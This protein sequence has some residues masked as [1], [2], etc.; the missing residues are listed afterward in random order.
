[1][2]TWL[3]L[4]LCTFILHTTAEEFSLDAQVITAPISVSTLKVM[5][6][7][8]EEFAGKY[9]NI[10]DLLQQQAGI[11]VRSSGIGNPVS[12]SI[13]GSSHQQVKFIVDGHEV[14]DAQYGGFDLNKISL[15]QV[16]QV[17]VIQGSSASNVYGNAV[18]GSILIQTLT[19]DQKAKSKTFG[20]TGS[21]D[22]QQ[23]GFTHYLTG[24]GV[25][26]LSVDTLKSK[27]DY[28]YAV[29]SPYDSPDERNRVESLNNNLYE[30]NTALIKWQS[31][32]L[33][34]KTIGLKG[35]YYESK[36]HLPNYQQNNPNNNAN[37]NTDEWEIQ[38]YLSQELTGKWHI[39]TDLS[40]TR[41]N[42]LFDDKNN[43]IGINSDFTEYDNRINRLKQ[44]LTYTSPHYNFD[45]YYSANQESFSDNH[46]LINNEIKCLSPVSTCD[47]ESSQIT[48]KIGS[49][50]SW[51]SS[52]VNHQLG[53][54]TDL[55]SLKRSQKELYADKEESNKNSE[56]A[57]WSI[58]YLNS[59][60]IDFQAAVNLSQAIR[61][62]S[63]YELFGDRGL[64]KSNI[65][66]KPETSN[67]FSVDID[68]IRNN[69][70]LSSGFFYRDLKDAIV[71]QSSGGIGTYKNLSSAQVYGW[72]SRINLYTSEY[73]LNFNWQLQDS[74]TQSEI[75]A[76]NNKKLAGIYHQSFTVSGDYKFSPSMSANYQYQNDAELY[77]DTANLEKHAGRVVHNIRLS[78][79]HKNIQS[80][81]TI[82]NVLNNQYMDQ[83]NR[84]AAG[85]LLSLSIQY[86]L[87]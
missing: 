77:V 23:L 14:N 3:F 54:S 65:A 36:K 24:A 59:S 5:T 40:M 66:L 38:G 28:E 10:S 76:S 12:I 63:L 21:Y 27:A 55:I 22:T 71:A 79:Q 83:S 30:K 44:S 64:A 53:V 43:Q 57:S 87:N 82:D 26:L 19:P 4:S 8:H 50:F 11:Q 52:K 7:N 1:M 69:I 34:N 31:T 45:S 25:G 33:E 37:I 20:S 18:G 73:S 84:P 35:S 9:Q 2:R 41:K 78:Y 81:F 32:H 49:S 60:K 86:E 56:H 74:Y 6:F 85:R 58:Q 47:I 15:H 72:Q 29:K 80:T 62:P 68:H 67:N 70:S 61:I 46:I 42:E 17:Q 48:H 13:R 16:Q 51:L 39:K 75:Y